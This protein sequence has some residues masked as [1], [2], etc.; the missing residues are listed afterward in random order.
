[1]LLWVPLGHFLLHYH[2]RFALP[3]P[4]GGLDTQLFLC[5]C[6]NPN[7]P[8]S[9]GKHKENWAGEHCHLYCLMNYGW[10]IQWKFCQCK[11]PTKHLGRKSAFKQ[12]QV[13][14]GAKGLSDCSAQGNELRR[15]LGVIKST[16]SI[17]HLL[18]STSE[19]CL[20]RS[21]ALHYNHKTLIGQ[22]NISDLC[23][24]ASFSGIGRF[25]RNQAGVGFRQIHVPRAV[26]EECFW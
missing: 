26:L 7:V 19:S 9:Y 23:Q 10:V 15:V 4:F 5:I 12:A 25:S 14:A 16:A 11:A 24:I 20:T 2:P 21:P 8:W 18:T 3:G 22:K 17:F 13:R 1:M 6:H